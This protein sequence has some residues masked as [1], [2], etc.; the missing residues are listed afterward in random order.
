MTDSTPS[1]PPAEWL[2]DRSTDMTRWWDGTRWTEHVQPALPTSTP[3][4][5][6]TSSQTPRY[7]APPTSKNGPAKA[8]L[9][10]ILINLLLG[11]AVVLLFFAA[12][13]LPPWTALSIL[14][15]L[16]LLSIATMIAA[17]VLAIAGLVISIRR[18]TRK[19]ES[20]FALVF[21]TAALALTVFRLFDQLAVLGPL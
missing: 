9:I 5:A 12:S 20:V 11:F 13:N 21:S 7:A 2:H 17:F 1:G 19:R 14:N 10:L 6:A 8:S 4:F 16:G 15:M 3:T 18:P